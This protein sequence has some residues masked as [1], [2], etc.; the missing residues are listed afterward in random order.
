[1]NRTVVLMRQDVAPANWHRPWS[2]LIADADAGVEGFAVAEQEVRNGVP[3]HRWSV[4]LADGTAETRWIAPVGWAAYFL[5]AEHKPDTAALHF[6][7]I[8][9]K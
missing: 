5:S 2:V 1:M 7:H 9:L 6:Q 8:V 3:V 4:Q